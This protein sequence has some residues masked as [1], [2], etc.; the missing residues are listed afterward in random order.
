MSAEPIFVIA[1]ERHRQG[2]LQ[3]AERLYRKVLGQDPEH[4]NAL[5]LSSPIARQVVT[6]TSPHEYSY[7]EAL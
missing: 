1:T 7:L 4:A 3:Q 6:R 5:F 2:Q